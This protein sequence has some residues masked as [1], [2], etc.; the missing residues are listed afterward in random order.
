MKP[1]LK[2]TWTP[3]INVLTFFMLVTSIL[4]VLTRLGTKYFMVRKWGLDDFMSI[5]AMVTCL[6]QS[7]AVSM[8]TKSGLGQHLISLSDGERVS[9][10]KAQ[11]AA[12]I[13]FVTSMACSKLA[14][15][16]F[17]RSLTPASLDRRFALGLGVFILLWTIAGGFH[18]GIPMLC[19]R[20]LGLSAWEMLPLGV[21]WWNYLGITNILSEIG[22]V[23][24]AL[25][26]ILRIQAD[27]HKKAVLASVFL[28]R[29]A[30]VIAIICQLA[31]AHENESTTD[32]SWDTW[33]VAISTQMVQSLSIVTACSPQFKPFLDSLRSSGMS[34]GDSSY[35]SKQRTYGATSY[36]KSSR[37]GRAGD[38][39]SDT[40][41]LVPIHGDGLNH[42]TVTST[43]DCDTESQSSQAQIIRE[44]R[45]WTVTAQ[46]E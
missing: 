17:I 38:M 11:Y 30:V 41:E 43:A 28:L 45:T 3:A 32:P 6:G 26:V 21:A 29:V 42:T 33:T 8:A 44:V 4:S 19:T 15:V 35:E 16:M 40:H 13:L 37:V 23:A 1:E 18:S 22:I 34:L 2:A 5:G 27:F 20:Y 12:N 7:I 10:M 24:Q 9:M 14:L 25:L 31:Y 36:Y 46:R 39:R